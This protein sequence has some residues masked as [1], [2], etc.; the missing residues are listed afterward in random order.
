MKFNKETL[1]KILLI[2]GLTLLIVFIGLLIADLVLCLI[3]KHENL[4]LRVLE[5]LLGIAASFTL[6]VSC[7]INVNSKSNDI[8]AGNNNDIGNINSLNA[9]GHNIN[10]TV[11]NGDPNIRN[12]LV[13]LSNKID[14]LEKKNVEDIINKVLERLKEKENVRPLDPDFAT[15][16]IHDAKNISNKDIQDIWAA[17]MVNNLTSDDLV[18]KRTL[19]IVKNLSKDEAMLFIE[20]AK[21]S[22]S[23]GLIYKKFLDS[24]KYIDLSLMQDIGLLKSDLHLNNTVTIPALETVTGV[25]GDLVI[26]IQ[27]LA[28]VDNKSIKY[29]CSS[30]TKEGVELKRALEIVIDKELLKTFVKDIKN[31]NLKDITIGLHKLIRINDDDMVRYETNEI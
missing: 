17:L 20:L 31:K 14:D 16:F 22:F 28:N 15:K 5:V 30:L 26:V 18:S 1:K 2:C 27:N 3:E 11:Y 4:I 29:D 24:F 10:V 21:A 8:N 12:E 23:S 6:S 7:S 9:E 13:T 19:D 25:E